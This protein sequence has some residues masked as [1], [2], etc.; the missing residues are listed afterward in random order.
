MPNAVDAVADF[1]TL[2]IT[3]NSTV[4]L[5]GTETVGSL[6]FGDTTPS[7][8]WT[9][10]GSAIT[11]ATSGTAVPSL[12]VNSGTTTFNAALTGTQGF[13]KSGT[14]TATLSAGT[15]NVITGPISVNAG[16]LNSGVANGFKNVT[17]AITVVSGASFG[18]TNGVFDGNTYANNLFLSGTGVSSTAGALEIS[19]NVTAT[20]TITLNASSRITH[21]YNIGT[22]NG[23]II[24]TNTNLTLATFVAGQYGFSVGGNIQ[25]GTGALILNGIGTTGSP[26]ATLSGSNSYSGGTNL[27]AGTLSIANENAIS[28]STSAINFNGGILQV[29]GTG[30][31]NLNSHTINATT[32]NGGIDVNSASNVFTVSQALSGT[33]AFN[34]RGSGSLT[35]SGSNSHS[36]GTTVTSG[37]LLVGN[38]NA[39]G[40]GVLTLNAGTVD[41]RGNNTAA[42]ALSGSTGTLI[43]N[44]ISGTNTLTST[45]ASGT[46]TYAG[47]IADGT[48]GIVLNKAGAGTQILSGTNTYSG[49]TT[50]SAGA[51]SIAGETAI[52]GSTSTINFNGGLLQVTGTAISNL[53]SHT[54]NWSSFNGGIDVNS[55]SN[56]FTVSQALSGTGA[57]S[58]A[59][60]GTLLLSASNG[61]SGGTTVGGGILQVGN[62]NALGTGVLAVNAGTLDLHGNNTAGGA[63]SGSTG[64]LITNSVSGT[65]SLTST[66][67]SGT[68][69]YAGTIADSTGVVALNKAGAGT[70]T[71]AGTNTFSG[72]ATISSGT[73]NYGNVNA[74]GSGLATFAG[75]STLQAGVSGTIANAMVLNP[76]VIG[77]F[78]TQGNAMGLS[79]IVSG[80]ALNKIG[81]GTLTLS[82]SNSYSGGTTIGAGTL[83]VGSGG[84]TGVLAGDIVNNATLALKRSDSALS[85][86]GAISGAGALVN[87][88][89]GVVTLAGSNSYSGGTT[90]SAGVLKFA[91]TNAVPGS[92][93]I[94]IGANAAAAFDF[95]GVQSVLN[96]QLG[97]VNAASSIALTPT[98]AGE[99]IDLSTTGANRNTYLGATG[100][101]T[102]TGTLTPF[103]AGAYQLGGGGGTLSFNQAIGGS[104]SVSIGGG[105]SGTVILG[106]ANSYSGGT[107][108]SG[109]VLEFASA[110][111]LPGSG[112]ITLGANSALAFDFTGV[113]AILNTSL[114]TANAASSIAVTANSAG[115]NIDLSA[116]G[117]NRNTYLGAVGTVTYTGTLTPFTAGAY[118]LG[119]GGGTLV[120]NQVI[121][122][123]SS[124]SIGGGAPGTVILGGSNNY[125][126]G[127]T[128][129]S[130][131]LQEG[132]GGSTGSIT[133]AIVNNG[134]LVVKRSD[135]AL[136]VGAI[137]GTGVLINAGT[138]YVGLA[139]GTSSAFSGPIFVNAGAF[140]TS[141]GASMK[142][143][144][145]A[146]TVAAGAT[147]QAYQNFDGYNF[148]NNFFLSGSGYGANGWGAL[149]VGGNA[150]TTGTITLNANAKISHDWNNGIINGPIVGA[151]TNLQLTTVVNGQNGM[152]IAG[153][154]QLGTGSLS[155]NG[156]GS[157]PDFT[158]SGSNNF[159]GGINLNAGTLSI[160][161]ENAISGSTST[162]NFNG[163]YLQITG[164]AI[165]SL[166]SHTIN[167]STFSG[168][169][170]VNSAANAFTLSQ[171]LSGPG[172][173]IKRGAGS[174][175]LSGSNTHSG[176]TTVSSGTLQAG[177]AN[178][179][180]TGVLVINAGTVDLHGNSIAF[181]ALSGSS[182][183]LI[184]NSVSG[185]HTLTS[186]VASGT[187]TYAGSIAD[188]AGAIA[189]SK[190]GAGTMILSGTNTYSGA[191][192]VN[193]GILSVSSTSALP[194]WD[195]GRFSVGT[196]ASLFVTNAFS[197]ANVGAML[198]S[199][200]FAA[201]SNLGLDISAGSRTFGINIVDPGANSLGLVKAGANT[202]VLSASNSYSGGTTL[203][204]GSLQ[205]GNASA[206]GATTGSLA[207]NNGTLDLNGN[208][209]TV[210]AL[211]GLSGGVITTSATGSITLTTNSATSGTFGGVIQQSGSSTVAFVKQGSGT[212]TMTGTNNNFTGAT[213]ISGG[214][215]SLATAM[216]Y[217]NLSWGTVVTTINGGATLVLG[218]WGDSATA[219]IGK[220]S[221]GSGNVVLD[222][223]TIR[224]TGGLDGGSLDRPF[225]IGAGGA[226]LD[227]AGGANTFTLNYGRSY[228]TI[229]SAAGGSLT[230][231]GSSNG[232]M[233]EY[234]P[235]TGGLVKSG[236][237]TW[238]LSYTNSYSGDTLVNGGMLLLGIAGAMA[239][240]TL[241]TQ[242]GSVGSLSFG[243][244]TAATFGGIKGSNGLALSNTASAA[245]ALTVGGNNQSTSFAGILSGGGSLIKNGTGLLTLTGSNVYS[246]ATTIS[247]G[248]LQVGDGATDG[249][250]AGSSGITDNSALV[251][252][253]L[254][255][256]TYANAISGS[257]SLTKSGAGTLALT[258]SNAYSGAT[259]IT[260]GTLQIGN[261]IS[262]SIATSSAVTVNSG[263]TLV[264]NLANSGT[265][266]SYIT[267]IG[268]NGDA[269]VIANASGTNTF[270]TNIAGPGAF[271][272]NGTGVTILKG[273]NTY[274]G[275]TTINA[276][277]L[278]FAST[279]AVPTNGTIA[280]NSGAAVAF[281]FTGVQT[282][283][284]A[285]LGMV[286]T[287]SSIALTPASAGESIN[288]GA[289]GANKNAY[290]GAMGNVTYTGTYTPFTAGAY[291][292]GGGGGTLTYNQAIG[293]A[294]SLSI[295]GGMPG[296]VILGGAN[297][298]SGGTTINSGTLQIGNG[299]SSGLLPGNTVNNATL[300]FNRSD[301]A[302]VISGAITGS[303]ALV[304]AGSGLVTLTG[305]NSY[306]GGTTISSGT[307]QIGGGGSTGSISGNIVNNATLVF[308]RSDSAFSTSGAIS[309][310]GALVNAGSGIVTLAGSNSYSGGT[311]I[312]AGILKFASS[313]AVPAIGLINLGANSA[314]AFDFTGVQAILNTRLNTVD[315]ASSIALTPASAGENIDLSVTGANKNT[316]LGAVE[317]VIYTGVYTPFTAG[318]YQFGGGGGTLTYNQVIGG[319]SS[320]SIGGG[321]PGTVVLGGTNSY[322]GGT[323]IGAGILVFSSTDAVPASGSITLGANTAVGFDFTGVQAIL[324]SRL[325][326]VSGTSTIAVTAASANE[327]INLSATGANKN[328]YL[329]AVG[330]VTYT[331]SYT[332]YTAGAYLLGGGGG[333][334][335]YDQVISGSSTVSI[336]GGVPGTVVLGASN[337]YSG[338][339][340]VSSG[341]LN[342]GNVR[343]LGS[344][345]ATVSGNSTVQAGV[346]GTVS[347]AIVLGAGVTGTFDSQSNTAVLSGVLSGSGALNKTGSGALILTASSSYS[348][349]T[350]I[351]SGTLQLGNNGTTGAV[352]GAI[353][354]NGTLV[355]KR[356][357][358]GLSLGAIS[359][360]GSMVNAG[361]GTV[362]L[363]GGTNNTF[364]GPINVN[365]GA[366]STSA[367][368]SMKNVTGPVTVASG[369]SFNAQGAFDGAVVSSNFFVSGTGV[370]SGWGALNLGANV[371]LSGTIT[372]LGDTRITK[373][374]NAPFISG[375]ITGTNTS[376]LLVSTV[377]GQD[378]WGIGGSIQLGTGALTLKGV[379]PSSGPDLTLSGS[380]SY[381]GGTNLN[382]GVLSIASENA[383]GGS[384]SAINFNG[385]ILRV[386]G[387]AISNLN[388]HTLN[389]STFSG[390]ID[391]NSASNAFTVSQ[392]L[393]GTG[394]FIKR[395]AGSLM[396]SGSNSFSGGTTLSSGTLQAR[397]ANA[398]GTGK[399][400]LNAGTLDLHGTSVAFGALSG[401]SGTLITNTVGG[402]SALTSTVASGTSTYA[403]NIADGAGA[404]AIN[405]AGA[406]TLTL[407]GSN[408]YSGGTTVSGGT[409]QVGNVNALATGALT[410]NGGTLDLNGNSLAVGALSGSAG[411]IA[412]TV[413]GTSTLTTTVASGTATYEGAVV[414]GAGAV[415]LDKEGAGTLVL[416]GSISADRISANGGVTQLGLSGS[417]GAIS[418]SAA[419]T[420]ELTAN[421]VNSAKVLQTNSLSI[422]AGGT[423][424]LWDN[425][426]I[427]RDQTG[428]INQGANL[429]M[430]QSLA[431]TA[432]DNGNWDKPGI[433]SSSV[434]ADL[435]AYSVLTV[436]VY[437]N[438][439]L[440]V[441]SFEGI[442]GLSSDNGGNQVMLKT[443]YLGDFDGNGIV[444][445]ADYGWLDF[446]YG[447]GL[448]VG[449]LNGDGQVN[450]ADYNGIDY[451]YGYQAYGVLNGIAVAG[452]TAA[453]APAPS[454]TVPEPG[455]LGLL[456]AAAMG[457]FGR[458]GGRKPLHGK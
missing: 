249:S 200:T 389:G 269:V 237:G 252:N 163:G 122:G 313:D 149:N 405:K 71:L 138:G 116:T 369:A 38:T 15:N 72:G 170:D 370:S 159:T 202:L 136:S 5:T 305:S 227:A 344:G 343:A 76:S 332:P 284:N 353:V 42:G 64:A 30:I 50:L 147:F 216:L 139:G 94:T 352:A 385:G 432:F 224:Y 292:L 255:S 106:G 441:D 189:L 164:T 293:G 35:L 383:I 328:A 97:T 341:V 7:N 54:V 90:I 135:G 412:S 92:G 253:L 203:T 31:T 222:N 268:T 28:G 310:S 242:T 346:S 298:Y 25:L 358:G 436:M 111:A 22:I 209:L 297:T 229:A 99:N 391:V 319:S 151:N 296:M 190:A 167:G 439:V 263:G 2:N 112:S 6:I 400:I 251:Y 195:S 302:L 359:G 205:L 324:N 386:T 91:S 84:S 157:V 434:I 397:D 287:T 244:L 40:T 129:S 375:L 208:S 180:G 21:N 19:N 330:N 109:G 260:G 65:A 46:S 62:P 339:T 165:N 26:D 413:S 311:T 323:T 103:T 430:V 424:D 419:G 336:G 178:A 306:S 355:F 29:T 188:G 79:G 33:G 451:G 171:S 95:A 250:I 309:G 408:S 335:I 393:S 105:A 60:A 48:G 194:G 201:G 52:S 231:T 228:G 399:V 407:S 88:G 381:S 437:D 166:N 234:L 295:G 100:N 376:L 246:G 211:S 257:G 264:V 236:S 23:P 150:T 361:T 275:S 187:A 325:G 87:L 300:A 75:N 173:F 442:N 276:G 8:N 18:F 299:G 315:A 334:L 168:G 314:A 142:N 317:N 429:A 143:M 372:L 273:Y 342:Y 282:I 382:A 13:V 128:I 51:L 446:Y 36:G 37:T 217:P 447:Y 57:F 308:N 371:G 281:D 290:L 458:R 152:V 438:T 207:V 160:A 333:T 230:L 235:G 81:S 414:S 271:N 322:S 394:S 387:T 280:V 415:A 395:G 43:T 219:G 41:L 80:G 374:W 433:T 101:V 238:T 364:T 445:S 345:T 435:G 363:A 66:V 303:G 360:S 272:Q 226:T 74:L 421:G 140:G 177:S 127:T 340:T 398:L 277:V 206:L 155:L 104:S 259:T 199:G 365:A 254:G 204:S 69:T 221:F 145:G 169:I 316:Y 214:T 449:D 24:G 337:S 118:Q 377:V 59:G 192:A 82:G 362:T 182:G 158:L 154:I 85:L 55:A 427:L 406:G 123:S 141:A 247:S 418:I 454:E 291:H 373:D 162:I 366:M 404:V 232:V 96:A 417:V 233:N 181:G 117:A 396:L 137:S 113:Q 384:T 240:S 77:T 210:G 350:T 248:T 61:H 444:N 457:L 63:L 401:S 120:Y 453:S 130:G 456:I 156:A 12:T 307:L 392:A 16:A 278:Q 409:L 53:N 191:T 56:T 270:S 102:Y 388:N 390:G 121:G 318:A 27:N 425:A 225:T 58:K 114:G 220:V 1:N 274:A 67:P 356:T 452:V 267:T 133:G 4:T 354:N 411:S 431:N 379:D 402:T 420:M 329:G 44:N 279:G 455:T 403:G 321:T 426:L 348:G 132:N 265:F 428:G 243:A 258:G 174:L 320:L 185:L 119:G 443:T 20:G 11:L 368:A 184:T 380:N 146:V 126:G 86:G 98:S 124:L 176:G 32:F 179:L 134:T 378:G 196:G 410:V 107:T 218:G 213:T 304:N 416:S 245:V 223:G 261:G 286:G 347:N 14:G 266:G 161:S 49:G 110:T 183:T 312:S 115:E 186:T 89:S 73:L 450:S 256:Q 283:L 262:G 153:S 148:A 212:L 172:A 3:A 193:G 349:G 423:L 289:S 78:D 331:G 9:V 175:T 448:T 357:D 422:A 10:S 68:S 326:T 198:A 93:S 327:Y 440:G 241:N 285:R 34:K 351:S 39:L 367:G 144:S 45:A 47:T 197:E 17:G 108:I 294:S 301:S 83:Q 338:G 70:L 215:L 131:T 288:L 125:S 239:G